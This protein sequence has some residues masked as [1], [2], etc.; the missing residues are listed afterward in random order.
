[1]TKVKIC[2]ITNLDDALAAVEAG[3]DALG[4]NFY[5]PSPRFIESAAARDII[6]RLPAT[7]TAVGVFANEGDPAVVARVAGEAGVFTIQLHGDESPEYCRAFEGL[8]VIKALRV[9]QAF[10]PEDATAYET[11]AILLDAFDRDLLGG[12]GKVIDWAIA[13]QTRPLVNKLFLSGGL[14]AENIAAAITAV[15]PYGVDA[16]SRLESAPGRKDRQKTTD[17][18]AAVRGVVP[19]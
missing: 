8:N 5:R 16:C 12:T 11:D 3:A 17:F 19:I 4:F 10:R 18:I 6:A 14:S 15:R 2:G 9:N 1:M 13:A 7:V